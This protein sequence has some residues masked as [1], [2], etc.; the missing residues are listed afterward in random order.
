MIA[1]P[2][3]LIGTFAGLWLSGFS[4]NTLTLFAMVLAIGIVVD[5][6]IVVLENVER[7]MREQRM[8]AYEAAVE[9]MRE[10]S[11][12]IVAIVMVLCAVFVPVAFL[13]GIAGQLYKQFAVTVAIAVVLSGFVA[14][15]LTP[16]LCALMLR[17]G[18]HESK[19][20][21]PFNAGFAVL[22]RLF[23]GA[24]NLALR[25]RMASLLAFAGVLGLLA[26][27]FTRIPGSFVPPEDQGYVLGAV[28][29]PDGATLERTGKSGAKL[30]QMFADHPAIERMFVVVGFDLIGGGNK[31]NAATIFV[32]LKDWSQRTQSAPQVAGEIFMRAGGTGLHGRVDGESEAAGHQQFLQADRA[33]ADGRGR[34]REGPVARRA[35]SGRLRGASEHD[36]HTVRERLQQVWTHLPRAVAGRCEVPRQPR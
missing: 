1:V 35:R 6:A 20:F 7:L 33:P 10:V 28:I 9:A 29:L 24:V 16:A 14:L 5:D 27:L 22:T 36:G 4:I 32:P 12:A 30:Q 17:A 19:L 18:D 8:P 31:T 23:L 21:R 26:L 2:V 11:G 15:T 34:S 25:Q 3:S 13:G